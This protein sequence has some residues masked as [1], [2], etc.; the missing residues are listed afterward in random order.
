MDKLRKRIELAANLAII[1]VAVLIGL[2]LVKNYL[3]SNSSAPGAG[4]YRVPAGTR[5]PL[6]SVDWSGNG[7]TLLLVLQK[8]CHFCTESAP[9]YKELA[10]RAAQGK[11][12]LVAVLPQETADAKQ[13]LNSLQI[14]I[15]DVRQSS[16]DALGVRGTPTLIL[17]DA[18]GTVEDSWVGKLPAEREAEV[19][20]RIETTTGSS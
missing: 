14:P 13:Y 9:F 19:L 12:R 4:D 1:I 17:V 15:D 8:G 7:R 10:G 16:L 6:P 18:R 2:V 3:L 5:V 20:R 11:V